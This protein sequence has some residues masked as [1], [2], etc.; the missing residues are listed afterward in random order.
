M[1]EVSKSIGTDDTLTL[2]SPDESIEKLDINMTPTE[3]V[4][5]T[6]STDP[7]LWPRILGDAE[8]SF[9]VRQGPP[10][11]LHNYKFPSNDT[12]R[13]FC[14]NYYTRILSNGEQVLRDWLVY[15][16]SQN[17]VYC[18]CCKIFGCIV[19]SL[20]KEDFKSWKHLGETLKEHEISKNHIQ[21]Q[22]IM[23]RNEPKVKV[24]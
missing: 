18:F 24:L 11:P 9:L 6:L 22:K 7:A 12:G 8:R 21:A 3:S 10:K 4:L 1:D 15:S 16:L 20:S 14:A 13:H 5:Q 23:A 19:S 2:P 17:C